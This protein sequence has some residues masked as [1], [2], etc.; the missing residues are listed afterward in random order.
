MRDT[1]RIHGDL[2]GKSSFSFRI[3]SFPVSVPARLVK[4]DDQ[5]ATESQ[6]HME[7]PNALRKSLRASGSSS[8]NG[9]ASCEGP[10]CQAAEAFENQQELDLSGLPCLVKVYDFEE[11]KLGLNNTAEFVGVLAYEQ[12]V[13][14]Q[15]R[16]TSPGANGEVVSDP[17][18]GLESFAR[19][20]PPPSLAPRLHCICK[21]H[22]YL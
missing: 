3:D 18:Q 20:I 22:T 2:C 21:R 9:G 19:K 8:S 10:T 4:D 12:P 13:P 7:T 6:A 11:S 1:Y 17:F 15:Q 5:A 16:S 14:K